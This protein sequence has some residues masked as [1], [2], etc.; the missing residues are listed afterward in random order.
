MT[1]RASGRQWGANRPLK[2]GTNTT[3]PEIRHG[4]GKRLDLGGVVDDP[5][6]IAQPLDERARDGDRALQR[7][8]GGRARAAESCGDR[9]D[10]AVRGVDGTSPVCMSMN[11]P[12]PYVHLAWPAS[13]QVCPNSAACWSPR[14]AGDRHAV[15]VE[16]TGAVDLGRAA[17][18]GEHRARDPELRED[19]RIP[20]ERLRGP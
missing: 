15:E 9:G 6:L 12:V 16:A 13:K 4:T 19:A 17:D 14:I 11:T 20:V 7:V 1:P 8:R 2:A 18:L 5:E 3:S 10:E